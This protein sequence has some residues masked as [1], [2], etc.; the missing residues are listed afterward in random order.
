MSPLHQMMM[1]GSTLSPGGPGSGLGG[2]SSGG[3]GGGSGGSGLS[4]L[5][6]LSAALG[7]AAVASPLSNGLHV[8]ASAE[9]GDGQASDGSDDESEADGGDHPTAAVSHAVFWPNGYTLS[10]SRES[11][12]AFFRI[13]EK[14]Y[15]GSIPLPHAVVSL[16]TAGRELCAADFTGGINVIDEIASAG[17]AGSVLLSKIKKKKGGS[18]SSIGMLNFKKKLQKDVESQNS[19]FAGLVKKLSEKSIVIKV[20][21]PPID[22]A[23]NKS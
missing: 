8:A 2:G 11:E 4:N 12:V 19:G 22:S 7:A 13:E 23:D 17:M 20:P 16:H 5:D 1:F 14:T 3:G 21:L 15:A 18:A 10:L 6:P 9:N